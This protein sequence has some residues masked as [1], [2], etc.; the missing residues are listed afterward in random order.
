MILIARSGIGTTVESSRFIDGEQKL[1][2]L[3]ERLRSI[4]FKES[5][6]DAHL[7]KILRRGTITCSAESECTFLLR[8]IVDAHQ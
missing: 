8:P 1:E 6:P 3:G 2:P 4:H 5:F 7:E